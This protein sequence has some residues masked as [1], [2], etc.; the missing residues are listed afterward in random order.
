MKTIFDISDDTT[1]KLTVLHNEEEDSRLRV[2][3]AAC[4]I[5]PLLGCDQWGDGLPTSGASHSGV[6]AFGSIDFITL[7]YTGNAGLNCILPFHNVFI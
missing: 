6:S 2:Q 7:N 5:N 4:N 3:R 1:L